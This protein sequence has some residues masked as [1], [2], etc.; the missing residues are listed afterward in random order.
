MGWCRWGRR[1]FPIF[2]LLFSLLFA[3]LRF[4]LFFFTFLFSP[5]L[6]GGVVVTFDL[7]LLTFDLPQAQFCRNRE[8]R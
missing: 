7:P 8:L 2:L 6:L 4:S 5:I 3:I 1:D